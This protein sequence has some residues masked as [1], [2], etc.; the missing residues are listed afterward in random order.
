MSGTAVWYAAPSPLQHFPALHKLQLRL[1]QC[2]SFPARIQI[3][4]CSASG[5]LAWLRLR[6][7]SAAAG[8]VPAA[9]MSAL[10]KCVLVPTWRPLLSRKPPPGCSCSSGLGA[11]SA[12]CPTVGEPFAAPAASV[13]ADALA[14]DSLASDAGAAAGCRP[15]GPH[16]GNDTSC[17]SHLT[18][19]HANP[20]YRHLATPQAQ[21]TIIA[22]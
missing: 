21:G 22:S 18:Q 13:F 11:A 17:M 5:A 7:P 8:T 19:R 15:C 1:A 4:T 2:Q 12:G 10:L 20:S 16:P 9:A 14:S 6:W 3:G